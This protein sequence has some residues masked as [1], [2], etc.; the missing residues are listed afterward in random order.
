MIAAKKLVWFFLMLSL[1]CVSCQANALKVHVRFSDV[2]G[3][4]KG[5]RVVSDGRQIGEVNNVKYTSEGDYLVDVVVP[6]E[7][8]D[9]LTENTRFYLISDPEV[10]N[11]KAIEVVAAEE[12]GKPLNNGAVVEGLSKTQEMISN[13]MADMQKGLGELQNEVENFLDSLK[14]LPEKDQIKRLREEIGRLA[15]QMKKAG[16]SAKERL[17][18]EVLP[19]IEEEIERL[20]ERLK[21]LGR[22]KE[23]EPLEVDLNK[24]K[25]I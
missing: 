25:R 15:E 16:E 1:V 3:L 19:K 8:K 11:K 7:F 17:E 22:E 18:R 10:P 12:P 24:L 14:K 4:V 5:D 20:K 21:K 13:V 6:E 9:K 23:V 2:E